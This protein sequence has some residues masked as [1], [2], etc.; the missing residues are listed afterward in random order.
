LGNQEQTGMMKQ[1]YIYVTGAGNLALMGARQGDYPRQST[2]ILLVC[3]DQ[4][5][6]NLPLDT[7]GNFNQIWIVS[8]PVYLKPD[9]FLVVVFLR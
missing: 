5:L 3:Q 8:L 4:W 9:L 6:Q 2:V 1:C 7:G